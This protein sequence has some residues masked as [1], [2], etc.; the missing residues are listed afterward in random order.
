MLSDRRR[1]AVAS[2]GTAEIKILQKYAINK[3]VASAEEPGVGFLGGG[4]LLDLSFSQEKNIIGDALHCG[5]RIDT[6]QIPAAVKKAWLQLELA[7]LA[8]DNPDGRPTKA[9]RQ[10]AREAVEARCEEEIKSDR[11]LR[12][13]QFPVLWDARHGLLYFG[14]GSATAAELCCDLFTQAFGLELLPMTASRR[15]R[16]WAAEAKRRS[17]ALR[18]DDPSAFHSGA[19]RL[20]ECFLDGTRK[21]AIGIFS[22]TS[23]CS[24]SGSGWEHVFR[25]DRLLAD[26]FEVIRHVRSHPQLA[27]SARRIGQGDNYRRGSDRSARS[28]AG[29]PQR[30][31]AAEGGHD[32]CS[33]NSAIMYDLA[34]Q[35]ER[36]CDRR[37]EDPGGKR[38]GKGDAALVEDRI[39]SVRNLHR[40][41]RSVVHAVLRTA[42][43]G[44]NWHGELAQIGQW[45]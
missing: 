29:H 28:D 26:G 42:C 44:K 16:N 19:T 35:P 4:H 17:E 20:A 32:A 13:S 1:R 18:P 11:F 25:Y 30:Q 10:E 24:G 12:M 7:A 15:A 38:G 6:H 27:V 41:D 3:I 9:Q 2:L 14:G 8:A 5:I 22:A 40:D 33:G 23:S 45:L 43:V 34:I 37:G 21:R 36:D 31:A 39:E